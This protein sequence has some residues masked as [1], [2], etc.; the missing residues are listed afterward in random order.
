[1]K[2]HILLI[3]TGVVCVVA[4]SICL[5]RELYPNPLDGVLYF[6]SDL[7]IERSN[8]YQYHLKTNRL[9]RIRVEGYDR[10]SNV[11][12][13]GGGFYCLGQSA[14][15]GELYV[16]YCEGGRVLSALPVEHLATDESRRQMT[17]FCV[18]RGGVVFRLP[19]TAGEKSCL[20]YADF[21]AKE[22]KPLPGTADCGSFVAVQ[23]G[24]LYFNNLSGQVFALKEG[25]P[26][27]LF[28]GY[29]PVFADGGTL[30]Y[31]G[32]ADATSEEKSLFAYDIDSG[33]SA[34]SQLYYELL[35]YHSGVEY[36]GSRLVAG[37]WL[38]G[39]EPGLLREAHVTGTGKTTFRNLKTGK[40]IVTPKLLFRDAEHLAYAETEVYV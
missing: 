38:I 7:K 5:V 4:F 6:D 3:L 14:A 18:Y 24:Q 22:V 2:K 33:Q 26:V 9:R 30:L 36:G 20:Y 28:E 16:L 10:V 12:P 27:L 21:G 34:S 11:T 29:E 15:N 39:Y 32:N 25:N 8:A 31:Y 35:P 37:G 40:R 19:G 1:M 23:D 17:N 13:G